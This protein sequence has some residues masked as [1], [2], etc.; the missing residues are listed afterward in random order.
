MVSLRSGKGDFPAELKDIACF[1]DSG[2]SGT[3]SACCMKFVP[4]GMTKKYLIG[5][6][7]LKLNGHDRRNEVC[8]L[9]FIYTLQKDA[10]YLFGRVLNIVGV[11]RR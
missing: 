10:A 3:V 6:Y 2:G 9:V 4:C 8:V 11:F 5:D 1:F 7:W